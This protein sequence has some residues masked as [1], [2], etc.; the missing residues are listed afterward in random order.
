MATYSKN[1]AVVVT[2]YVERQRRKVSSNHRNRH[3]HYLHHTIKQE[4]V[5]HN[6]GGGAGKGY[7][8]RAELLHYSRRLRES[9]RLEALPKPLES[10]P[11][12]STEQPPSNNIVMNNH[13]RV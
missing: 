8:R 10:K 9:A 2:V 13:D 5:Q 11:V 4:L 1:K 7:N 3:Q 6:H 12:S